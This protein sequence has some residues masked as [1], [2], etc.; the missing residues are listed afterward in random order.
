MLSVILCCHTLEILVIWKKSL[1]FHFVW[2]PEI[3]VA[4]PDLSSHKIHEIQIN[5]QFKKLFSV[6]KR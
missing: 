3:Y 4:S 6:L 1:D 5:P 2:D